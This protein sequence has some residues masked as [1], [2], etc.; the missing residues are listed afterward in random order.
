MREKLIFLVLLGL[1]LL[2]QSKSVV[3]ADDPGNQ[4]TCRVGCVEII[5]PGQQVVIP[6]TVYNDEELGGLAVPL[7]FGH[8]PYD[9]VCDSISFEGTR[10]EGADILGA[11][12]DTANYRLIFYIIYYST[13]LPPDDGIVANLFFTTGPNWDTTLCVQVDSTFFPPTTRLEFTPRTSGQ[14]LYPRLIKGCLSTG[15]APVP[16]LIIPEDQ[17]YTCSPDTF[18]FRWSKTSSD[19]SYMLQYAQDADFTTGLVTA[20]P[21]TDTS[22]S[23]SLSWGT[24]Y[25]HVKSINLC[26]K[27]SAYQDSPFSFYVYKIGDVTQDGTV[28]VSDVIYLINYL[29]KGGPA[30]VPMEC[31]N[32]SGDEIVDISDAVYLLNYLFKHG[33]TPKC[34]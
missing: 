31:A 6:V 24:Y 30:P 12:I 1:L 22:Y 3:L 29:Y 10:S 8:A 33:P 25:W 9:V 14:A 11:K 4:D 21:F 16:S 13:S 15:F 28:D 18:K 26:G 19:L 5:Q 2:P 32:V 20:G 34:P 27:E 17:G 7:M 23:A